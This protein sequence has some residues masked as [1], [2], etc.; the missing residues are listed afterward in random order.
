MPEL[1]EVESARSLVEAHCLGAEVL[2]VEYNQDG[3][4]DEKIFA[5]TTE[6]EFARAL[7]GKTLD[8]TRRHGGAVQVELMQLTHSLK[9]PGFNP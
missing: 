2:A 1:P 6:A 7:V 4:F 9:A 3:T 5:G 8:A